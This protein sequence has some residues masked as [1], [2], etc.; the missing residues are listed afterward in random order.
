MIERLLI[1]T[2]PGDDPTA[3]LAAAAK[4]FVPIS[5]ETP[6]DDLKIVPQLSERPTIYQV[7]SELETC[8]W[9][10][11]QIVDRRTIEAKEAQTGILASS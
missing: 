1:A 11:D 4:N 6:C 9:Y 2:P 8:N 5:Q 7:V 10:I 3:L